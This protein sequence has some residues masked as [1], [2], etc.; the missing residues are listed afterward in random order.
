MLYFISFCEGG[1]WNEDSSKKEIISDDKENNL[2][3]LLYWERGLW[4]DF[5]KPCTCR[6]DNWFQSHR[7]SEKF[8]PRWIVKKS[9]WKM[10]LL[11]L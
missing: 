1:V 3:L 4:S 8:W 6:N 7:I 9:S 11:K 10:E 5:K 2:I